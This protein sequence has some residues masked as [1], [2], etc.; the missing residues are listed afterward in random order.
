MSKRSKRQDL[1]SDITPEPKVG[2]LRVVATPIG[3]LSD[4]STRMREALEKADLILAEDT[5]RTLA[6]LN[7]LH[8]SGKRVERCDAHVERNLAPRWLDQLREGAQLSLVSDAGTP[9]IS[10]PG[11]FLV[12]EALRSGIR[13]E[14]IPGPSAVAAFAS[15]AGFADETAF[16]FL[17]FFPRSDRDRQEMMSSLVSHLGPCRVWIFFESPERVVNALQFLA[18]SLPEGAEVRVVKELT[19]VHERIFSG[20]GVEVADQVKNEVDQEGAR[21]EWC[22]A[23]QVPRFERERAED[24][25]S[26]S[27]EKM[28]NWRDILDAF[29]DSGLRDSDLAKRVS[30]AFGI[31]RRVVYEEIQLRS[32]RQSQ[33]NG[34]GELKES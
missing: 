5:R 25:S 4:V 20:S 16:G 13:V 3:N 34:G 7:A 21:G 11:S 23:L 22:L 32:Q 15:V 1:P 26:A 24:V 12:R 2:V 9:G 6:L 27:I 18:G 17:G 28:L 14:P 31:E 29:E 33:K 8:L 30:R 19:K 10:D